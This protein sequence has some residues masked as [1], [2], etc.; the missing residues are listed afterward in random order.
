MKCFAGYSFSAERDFSSSGG[1]FYE[2]AKQVLAQKGIVYASVYNSD[3]S[4]EYIRILNKEDLLR[5]L[6]AKYTQSKLNGIFTEIR[7][8]LI[9]RKMVLICGLPCQIVGLQ[10]YLEKSR[11]PVDLLTTLELFCFGEPSAFVW[12]KYVEQ[13][14]GASI[15]QSVNMR[16]KQYGW[17]NHNYHFEYRLPEK[18]VL[19]HNGEELYM[20]GYLANLYTKPACSNC[21]CKSHSRKAD[22]SL[23]DFW[24]I[25]SINPEMDDDKGCSA[26]IAHTENGLSQLMKLQQS[27]LIRLTEVAFSDVVLENSGYDKIVKINPLTKP[28]LTECRRTEDINSLI[29]H[30]LEI[31][32]KRI[33]IIRAEKLLLLIK[34]RIFNNEY[35]VACTSCES[36]C[37]KKAIKLVEN[38]C[39]FLSPSVNQK[40]CV[41]C[42]LCVQACAF[43]KKALKKMI[44]K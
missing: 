24:G 15:L 44:N 14:Y 13:N 5:S 27:H 26:I 10:K 7:R 40:E 4:V 20:R 29:I 11:T 6:G 42:G 23:G 43:N 41:G 2:L 33:W 16:S 32:R 18:T 12:K 35:C 9:D 30:F 22:I 39:G 37:P 21:Q 25:S 36:I 1:I 19:K 31:A 3:Y 17:S 38:E 28:F 8:D 34:G